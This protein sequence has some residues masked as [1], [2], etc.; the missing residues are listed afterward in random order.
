MSPT[1][2]RFH[3]ISSTALMVQCKICHH[4]IKVSSHQ[5]YGG[6]CL[7]SSLEAL[8]F[9]VY[10]AVDYSW[11]MKVGISYEV[12]NLKYFTDLDYKKTIDC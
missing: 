12:H 6:F 10:D 8:K 4:R 9:W 5:G 2:T 3:A 11:L 7:D 1:L